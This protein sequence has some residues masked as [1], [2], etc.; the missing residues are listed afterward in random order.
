MIF[1]DWMCKIYFMLE[2]AWWKKQKTKSEAA[3]TRLDSSTK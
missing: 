1:F 2:V 3:L